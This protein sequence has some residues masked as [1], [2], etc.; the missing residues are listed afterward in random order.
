MTP[1]GGRRP[2]PSPPSRPNVISGKAA[3][4]MLREPERGQPPPPGSCE[5]LAY[6]DGL[7]VVAHGNTVAAFDFA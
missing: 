6:R 7:L 4:T 3:P 5:P 1:W 2:G